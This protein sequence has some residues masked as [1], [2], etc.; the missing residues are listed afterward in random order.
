MAAAEP[1]LDKSAKPVDQAGP[2]EGPGNPRFLQEQFFAEP[3][4]PLVFRSGRPFGEAGDTG[5]SQSV[6]FPAPGALAGALRNAWCD[7]TGYQ[8]R[9]ADNLISTLAVHGPLYCTRKDEAFPELWLPAPA[10]ARMLRGAPGKTDKYVRLRPA[11][12]ESADDGCDLPHGLLPVW[13]RATDTLHDPPPWW[14]ASTVANWLG[15]GN[16]PQ[17][18]EAFSRQALAQAA[19]THIAVDAGRQAVNG[20]LFR[21]RA[22]DFTEP[23]PGARRPGDGQPGLWLR[24]RWPEKLKR[25]IAGAPDV[26]DG[27]S[28]MAGHVWRLGADGALVAFHPLGAAGTDCPEENRGVNGPAFDPQRP[29]LPLAKRL[30]NLGK[31][32]I[33][34]M[35]LVTPACYA[36]NGWYPDGLQPDDDQRL[37]GCLV[38]MPKGWKLRLVAAAVGRFETQGSLKHRRLDAGRADL[39]QRAGLVKP[40]EPWGRPSKAGQLLRLVPA[41]SMYWLEVL[42]IG[43]PLDWKGW[44]ARMLEPSCRAE[45]ARD[46][47]G[48]AIYARQPPPES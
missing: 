40:A 31:G 27:L 17:V 33:L 41:G 19:R 34:R 43:D 3:L 38:G 45:H 26:A 47:Y 7:A 21:T 14:R 13:A 11:A 20:A 29:F 46:G 10:D 48:L 28:R 24:V 2:D 44:Y 30:E 4:S 9:A 18:G 6:E 37:V 32:D 5:D 35:L 16:A 39:A 22:L 25:P 36:R 8:P 1:H 23:A 15:S 42:E 12:S